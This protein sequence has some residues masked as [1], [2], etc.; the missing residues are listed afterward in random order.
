ML[1]DDI[2][3][4]EFKASDVVLTKD[5]YLVHVPSLVVAWNSGQPHFVNPHNGKVYGSTDLEAILSHNC[6]SEFKQHYEKSKE[7]PKHDQQQAISK[8]T[9]KLIL[10]V[11]FSFLDRSHSSEGSRSNHEFEQQHEDIAELQKHIEVCHPDEKMALTLWTFPSNTGD[12]GELVSQITNYQK[13]ISFISNGG[14]VH[15]GGW[16][17]FLMALT[18]RPQMTS[19]YFDAHKEN[20]CLSHKEELSNVVSKYIAKIHNNEGEPESSSHR[21]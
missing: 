15:T 1:E 3:L 2:R 9:V 12:N 7:M 14:C 17:L 6:M 10:R 5:R 19:D 11:V 16:K 8:E 4:D 13:V 20:L 18:L 21:P